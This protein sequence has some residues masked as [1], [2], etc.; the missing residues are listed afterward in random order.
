MTISELICEI[1]FQ[2]SKAFGGGIPKTKLLKLAYLVEVLYKRRFNKRITDAK[3]V[4]YL[5]G[6][7]LWDYNEILQ[8]EAFDTV[9]KS[10]KDDHEAQIINLKNNYHNEDISP[11]IKF[12]IISVVRDYGNMDLASLLD[13]VYFETEPMM[14]AENRKEILDFDTVLPEIHYKVKELKLEPKIEKQIRKE[15]RQKVEALRGKGNT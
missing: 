13:Y 12:L 15:F 7:Y 14:N 4:Y 11:D 6:P 1:L 9:S 8:N 10:I 2:Y 5:Y 3:W